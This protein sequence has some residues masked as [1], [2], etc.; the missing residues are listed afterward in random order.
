MLDEPEIYFLRNL[1]NST[2]LTDR[3]LIMTHA[4]FF[5]KRLKESF[6]NF[7]RFYKFEIL[8]IFTKEDNIEIKKKTISQ[9]F[10]REDECVKKYPNLRILK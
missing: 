7:M 9:I 5:Y 8:Q 10:F 1:C 2:L 4:A 3:H 6:K